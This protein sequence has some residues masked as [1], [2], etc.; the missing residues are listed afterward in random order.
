[1]DELHSTSLAVGATEQT[2]KTETEIITADETKSSDRDLA[3]SQDF[4]FTVI[5]SS[6]QLSATPITNDS[7]EL[8][9][10]PRE[11]ISSRISATKLQSELLRPII[12]GTYNGLPAYLLKL[13]F[14][15]YDSGGGRTWFSR[16]QSADISVLLEDAPSDGTEDGP[17]SGRRRKRPGKNV[18]H[19]SIDKVYPGTKGW[20]GPI[21]TAPVTMVKGTEFQAGWSGAGPSLGAKANLSESRST[22]DTGSASVTTMSTGTSGTQRNSLRIS[23]MENPIDAHGIL[24]YLVAPLIVTHHH[25]RFKMRVTVSSTFGFWR[26][27][28]AE[29][30]PV[31][32][33]SDDPLFFDPDVLKKMAEAEAKGRGGVKVV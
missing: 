27:M 33:R 14:Q 2:T 28:L 24:P 3:F 5:E 11:I 30:V 21:S 9:S 22:N 32:G 10:I 7:D 17:Q 23:I 29:S 6:S 12:A 26:G 13:Q 25:R 16:I 15:F 18:K 4:T 31:L 20:T 1:M 8:L 19:P